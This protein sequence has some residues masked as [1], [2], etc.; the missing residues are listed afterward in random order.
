[1]AWMEGLQHAKLAVGIVPGEGNPSFIGNDFQGEYGIVFLILVELGSGEHDESVVYIIFQ[2]FGG[3]GERRKCANSGGLTT[4]LF[5]R[6][7][8]TLAVSEIRA[9]KT[10][11]KT[12]KV[13]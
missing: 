8:E 3:M 4:P 6:F 12:G 7:G 10:K 5:F 13:R 1:M 9:K 2:Q 11:N